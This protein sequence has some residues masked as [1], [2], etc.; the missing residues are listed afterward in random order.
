MSKQGR[1]EFFK[2]IETMVPMKR[3]GTAQ[4]MAKAALF[5]ASDD[6][7]YTIGAELIADGGMSQL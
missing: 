2:N 3:F 6:S 1:E 5:L 7:T 4:E